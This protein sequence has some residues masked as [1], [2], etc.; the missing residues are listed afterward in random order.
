MAK[1][2]FARVPTVTVRRALGIPARRAGAFQNC[3]RGALTGKTYAKPPRGM[4]GRNN[5]AVHQAMFDAAAQ[6]G[7][8]IKKP[9]PGTA[10]AAAA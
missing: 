2:N 1:V 7:A 9:R 10:A 6:C 5:V 4:G 3:V 8:R